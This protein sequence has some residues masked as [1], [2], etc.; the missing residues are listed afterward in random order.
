[1]GRGA[2]LGEPQKATG[3]QRAAKKRIRTTAE[4]I[5]FHVPA[6]PSK[7]VEEV[8]AHRWCCAL[9]T[10]PGSSDMMGEIRNLREFV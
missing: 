2:V 9:Q 10:H 6:A 4:G 1:M 8:D 7:G 5:C 3:P